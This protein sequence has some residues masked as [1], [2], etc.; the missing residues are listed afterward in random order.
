MVRLRQ[1]RSG[2]LLVRVTPGHLQVAGF[3]EMLLVGVLR[4]QGSV[5]TT[6]GP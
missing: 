4:G 1:R 5:T 6:V 2:G 3:R